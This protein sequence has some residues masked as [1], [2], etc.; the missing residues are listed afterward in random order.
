[1]SS[2]RLT[3]RACES[4]RGLPVKAVFVKVEGNEERGNIIVVGVEVHVELSCVSCPSH[5]LSMPST[6]GT[7]GVQRVAAMNGPE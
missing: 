3:P 4:N 5:P 7:Y 6:T 1:M 2:S